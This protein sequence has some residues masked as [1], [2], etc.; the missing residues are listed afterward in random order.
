MANSTLYEFSLNFKKDPSQ[1][2]LVHFV[3]GQS[4]LKSKQSLSCCCLVLEMSAERKKTPNGSFKSHSLDMQT[5]VILR[6]R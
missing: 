1:P 3:L 4:L 6:K 2:I 5:I